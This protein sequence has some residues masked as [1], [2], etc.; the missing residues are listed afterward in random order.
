MRLKL[1][2]IYLCSLIGMSGLVTISCNDFLD[3]APL[4]QVTPE[5]YFNTVDQVGSYI[6]KYY[7]DYLVNSNDTKMYHT[8]TW[9]SGVLRND[10]NTDNLLA[11]ESSLKYFAGNWEVGEGKAIQ[12]PLNRIRTWNYLLEQVLPK[13]KEGTIQGSS[14]ELRHYIG[15]AYFFRAL[16]YYNALV[17]YGDYPIVTEVL[18]DKSDILIE[19][20]K[21]TPRNEVARFILKDLDE[22]I[23]RLKEQGFQNNQRINKQAAL[24]FKSRVALF[25]GTFEKYHR[26]TGRVPGDESW[27]GAKMSYNSGKTFDI[28]GEIN[29]FLNEAMTAAAAIADNTTLTENT[30]I[31]GPAYRQIYDWNPYFEMFSSPNASIFDEVILWKQYNK[32]LSVSHCVPIRVKVGDRT[33]LTR[34]QINTFLMKNGLPI[35]A[36]GSGYQ[37]DVSITKEKTGRDERLQLFVWGENDIWMTDPKD[38]DV[39]KKDR[40]LLFEKTR[41]IS[42][43]EQNRDITGYRPRKFYTF[44]NDQSKNDELLGSNGCVIFRS[45][46]ALLNYMEACYEKTNSLDNKA[47]AYW[48]ALRKRAGV[49]ED[50]TKTINATD[51]TQEN[52]LATYS[53]DKLVDA[54][55]Y[56]IR[57]E[58]R[59]E[60]IGEGMRW[61][62]LKRWRSWDQLLTKPYIIEGFNLWDEAYKQYVD[63]KGNTILKADGSTDANVS[64][65]EDSKYLRPLRRTKINN[66]FYDGLTWRKAYYLDPL[67]LQDLQLTSTDPNDISSS[68]MYQNPY[69]PSGTGKALE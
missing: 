44:D 21:R 62:D 5:A 17:K 39:S 59:C 32:S 68:V 36:S 27:P 8:A 66:Q 30:H 65:K 6:I 22:A 55:L 37:G 40:A 63:E 43:S 38:Q 35:Y 12:N 10:A 24:L 3:R 54:T 47:Q 49:D 7:D 9:S 26:G 34:A 20:S 13:E 60:F 11:D 42:D 52:D 50:Y 29:F 18:P 23:S 1:K 33:G 57:R 16:A 56:N 28:P 31:M 46:E 69:W 53:G 58:R 64:Q 2:Q 4:S 61:D 14:D 45:A 15:E 25:E 48:K 41:I 19:N 51:L 67:G